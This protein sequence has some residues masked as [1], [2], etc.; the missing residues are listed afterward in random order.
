MFLETEIC[1]IDLLKY[2][3]VDKVTEIYNSNEEFLIKHLGVNKISSEWIEKELEDMKKCGFLSCKITDK[4]S[5]DILG[6]MDFKIDD[7]TYLSLLMLHNRFSNKGL[8]QEVYLRFEEYVKLL[9]HKS[10]RIDVVN[11]YNVEV[12]R[13]W[14]KNGFRRV[15][16]VNLNWSNNLLTAT[17]M[18]KKL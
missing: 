6:I 15:K 14:I 4:H 16:E 13:F 3:D 1:Y 12:F 2:S 9:G 7:E 10:I 8:G 11:E 18:K 17:V 5:N